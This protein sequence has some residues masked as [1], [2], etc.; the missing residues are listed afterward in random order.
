MDV[1]ILFAAFALI[2]LAELGDKTQLAA[3]AFTTSARSPWMVFIGTSLAL[4]CTTALAVAFG[5]VLSNILPPRVLQ[6]VSAV[7]F[8][9]VGV[10][11]LVNLARKAP[12]E[13]QVA[14][15]EARAA[16]EQGGGIA[17]TEM[18]GLSG[19]VS[20]FIV[21]QAA[22][23]EEDIVNYLSE[24]VAGLNIGT[25]KEVI[26]SII[27]EDRKHIDALARIREIKARSEAQAGAE[28]ESGDTGSGES[29]A[30]IADVL[31]YTSQLISDTETE[32][33]DERIR[34]AIEAEEAASNFFLALARMA[35][36]HAARDSFRELAMEDIRH[37]QSLCSLVNKDEKT[38]I[39]S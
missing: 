32:A 13:E 37:A 7:L 5:E 18:S 10:F 26:E 8:I 28:Q 4:I 22:R 33:V 27:E 35:K 25:E 29:G 2:F 14:P 1:K 19:R 20:S 39:T 31:A 30:N 9:L 15:E 16:G 24:T 23:M 3:L 38:G 17:V 34:K 6:I 12:S 11:L 36:I 21:G